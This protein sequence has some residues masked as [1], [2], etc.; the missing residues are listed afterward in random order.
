M[1]NVELPADFIQV[2]LS[3]EKNFGS[4]LVFLKSSWGPLE[5]KTERDP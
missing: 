4:L 5:L 2:G 1:N 3:F